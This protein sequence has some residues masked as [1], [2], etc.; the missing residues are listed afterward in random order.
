MESKKEAITI[1]YSAKE[2]KTLNA[3]CTDN[4]PKVSY[5]SGHPEGPQVTGDKAD[6]K[7]MVAGLTVGITG[8]LVTG[9]GMSFMLVWDKPAL[10]LL[11]GLLGLIG[12]A[13]AFP[14]D[15]WVLEQE[16]LHRT[17][18]HNDAKRNEGGHSYE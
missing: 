18:S 12:V 16:Q 4:A 15:Q 1:T 13:M 17:K 14:L 10:G 8:V 9:L 2:Q 11:I 7:G 5:L 3:L 6:S